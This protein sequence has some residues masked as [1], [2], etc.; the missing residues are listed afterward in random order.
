[1]VL[2]SFV[3]AAGMPERRHLEVVGADRRSGLPDSNSRFRSRSVGGRGL[4]LLAARGLLRSFRFRWLLLLGL[5]GRLGTLLTGHVELLPKVDT[6]LEPPYSA[7]GR[8]ETPSGRGA[9]PRR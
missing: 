7:G 3:V 9:M 5:V 2:V 6:L 1:L 8:P 4:L